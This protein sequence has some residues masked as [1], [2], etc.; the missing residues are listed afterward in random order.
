[1]G[2]ANRQTKLGGLMMMQLLM[3]V[4]LDCGGSK[5]EVVVVMVIGSPSSPGKP[6]SLLPC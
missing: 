1:M 5:A 6:G 3:V 2:G 4:G